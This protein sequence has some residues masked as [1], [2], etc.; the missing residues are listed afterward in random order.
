MRVVQRARLWAK[1]CTAS[2][3]ALVGKRPEGRQLMPTPYFRSRMAF[4]ISAWR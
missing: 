4:P 2:Q 3:A 1:T